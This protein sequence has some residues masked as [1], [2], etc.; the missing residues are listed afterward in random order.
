M[1]RT[2]YDIACSGLGDLHTV[3]NAFNNIH[4]I[5]T[6][7]I[8]HFP[9]GHTAHAFAE[10]G[11]L[12]VNSWADTVLQWYDC[13]ADELD[14]PCFESESQAYLGKYERRLLLQACA[15]ESAGGAE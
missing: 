8:G 10:L 9:E 12:E 5:F 7:M 15:L 1:S 11:V 2:A 13:M 4:A 14:D 6:V 3:Q